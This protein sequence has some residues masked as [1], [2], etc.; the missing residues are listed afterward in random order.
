MLQFL[1]RT[2][3]SAVALLFISGA[4]QGQVVISGSNGFVTALIVAVVLG[5]ANMVVKPILMFA[6]ESV[7][8][9]LSCLTLG[10]W[11][12]LLSWLVSGLIFF[13]AGSG[14]VEGFRVHGFVPALWGSLVISGLN[15]VVGVLMR[16]RNDSN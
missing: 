16:D 1:V 13:I 3:L 5:L 6:A 7:T 9:L 8:C 11:S 12:I 14:L 15:A 10:L 2:A 4:S